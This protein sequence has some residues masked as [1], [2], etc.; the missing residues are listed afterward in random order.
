MWMYAGLDKRGWGEEVAAVLPGKGERGEVQGQVQLCRRREGVGSRH[1]GGGR[2]WVLGMLLDRL[3][4][5]RA[6]G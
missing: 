4:L 6:D 3:N 5:V 2:G 1:V